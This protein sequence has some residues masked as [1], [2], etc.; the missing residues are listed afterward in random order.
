[1]R[2]LFYRYYI[3]GWQESEEY[4]CERGRFTLDEKKRLKAG[5]TIKKDGNTYAVEE[6]DLYE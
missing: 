1:M 3:N 2:S 4:F 5:E 6:I